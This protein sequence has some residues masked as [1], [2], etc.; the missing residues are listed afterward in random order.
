MG[1][2]LVA[3]VRS[4]RKATWNQYLNDEVSTFTYDGRGNRVSETT[5]EGNPWWSQVI[6]QADFTY[7]GRD[8]V[9]TSADTGGN[10]WWG[11]DDKNARFVR[12]GLGR[13]LTVVEEGVT[14]NRLF[15]GLDVVAEGNIQVVRDPSGAVQSE[16]TTWWDG[17]QQ[18]GHWAIT[19]QDVLKDVLGS[20]IAVA[21]DGVVS[22]DLQLFGDFG[23]VVDAAAWTLVTG[24][25]GQAVTDGLTEFATRTYDAA[26]RVWLQA[27]SF[28]GTTTRSASLNRYAYVEGAP[29]S[30]VDV[31]GFYRAR[32]AV[33]AQALA[34]AQAAYDAALKAYNA[35]VSSVRQQDRLY[36]REVGQIQ[37]QADA[38]K[39]SDAWAVTQRE[40]ARASVLS[41]ST[42]RT[43][44]TST[45]HSFECRGDAPSSRNTSGWDA[46]S[47]LASDVWDRGSTL[48]QYSLQTT[49]RRVTDPVQT[50]YDSMNG[51]ILA[52]DTTALLQIVGADAELYNKGD[53]CGTAGICLTS[54]WTPVAYDPNGVAHRQ[55][56]TIG[57]TVTF[58]SG[59]VIEDDWVEHEFT[60][61]LQYEAMGGIGFGLDYGAEQSWGVVVQHESKETAY[62]NQTSEQLAR[63]VANDPNVEPGKNPLGH[64]FET[65]G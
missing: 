42:T 35:I 53:Y 48:V 26:S 21:V 37:S 6:Y 51:N 57:H 20:P 41:S 15:D 32:A 33:R 39:A 9:V 25:T 40:A 13:A 61:V 2:A 16:V 11:G 55:A 24:F 12:D 10:V 7:D 47:G 65:K 56:I 36:A 59:E 62:W 27:D 18:W 54:N 28:R 22:K 49:W 34:A 19:E 43:P 52:E 14:K 31:L 45:C 44:T 29:E 58:P 30:F 63:A 64:W 38:K 46:V 5:K 1:R 50:V 23:D 3:L 4:V 17:W 8:D 60:H